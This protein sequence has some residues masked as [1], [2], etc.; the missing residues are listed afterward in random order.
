MSYLPEEVIKLHDLYVTQKLP[1]EEIEIALGKSRKSLIAKL[2]R[3]GVY[4]PQPKVV[5]KKKKNEPSKKELIA[6]LAEITGASLEGIDPASKTALTELIT[7]AE[8]LV[9]ND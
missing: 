4:I 5:P 6:K 1:L 7:W 2:A 3:D 9:Q 8:G